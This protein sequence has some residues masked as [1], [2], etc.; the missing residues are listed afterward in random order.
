MT[1]AGQSAPAEIV[2]PKHHAAWII[3]AT[4][5]GL[6]CLLLCLLI[7]IYVRLAVS[8]L[9]G[10]ADIFLGFAAVWLH[11]LW[12]WLRPIDRESGVCSCPIRCRFFRGFRGLGDVDRLTQPTRNSPSAEG[13]I[14]PR[15]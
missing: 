5:L 8:P 13:G 15:V 1:P 10:S 2:D 14:I 9:A 6:V 11:N 12:F 7:R 4:A 3:I